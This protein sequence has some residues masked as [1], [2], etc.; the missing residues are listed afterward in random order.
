MIIRAAGSVADSSGDDEGNMSSDGGVFEHGTAQRLHGLLVV[1]P[2]Q[3]VAVDADQLV[4]DAETRVLGGGAALDDRLDEDAEV[5]AAVRPGGR[6]ALDG[7]AESG[8]F[9]RVEGD[10]ERQDFPLPRVRNVF[11]RHLF[12]G[13]LARQVRLLSRRRRGFLALLVG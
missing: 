11:L 5:V 3:R 13:D 4:V 12:G 8:R 7:D 1:H 2:Q 9:R 10:V 6:L